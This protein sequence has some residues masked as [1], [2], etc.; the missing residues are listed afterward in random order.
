MQP[1]QLNLFFA[2]PPV[3]APPAPV[4]NIGNGVARRGD[5]GSPNGWR[6]VDTE[7]VQQRVK[8]RPVV[9][10]QAI[11][12]NMD[13]WVSVSSLIPDARHN[14]PVP[15]PKVTPQTAPKT[16]GPKEPWQM[17][18]EDWAAS[19]GAP[20][21]HLSLGLDMSAHQ[22]MSMSDAAKW[23]RTKAKAQASAKARELYNA[24][25]EDWQSKVRDA[26]E[27]GKF[28]ASD[29]LDEDAFYVINE[30][31][32]GLSPFRIR[33]MKGTE[34]SRYLGAMDSIATGKPVPAN[35]LADYP[36]LKPA[37]PAAPALPPAKLPPS[38][39]ATMQT[40]EVKSFTRRVRASTSLPYAPG[41]V[42][43]REAAFLGTGTAEAGR[44]RVLS[45]LR[46]QGP[47]TLQQ[48]EDALGLSGNTVRPRRCE[49]EAA[50]L[51][52][53]S[54]KT[55]KTKSGRDAVL[56]KAVD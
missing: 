45:L 46:R 8:V 11:A 47:M 51:V 28:R 37:A 16:V 14:G 10:G 50:G 52:V 41:S 39:H 27:Q 43:S 24:A 31:M 23:D 19:V 22:M 44:A 1:A 49:L 5:L 32:G 4:W 40:V 18:R 26:Y 55:A 36:N 12:D 20:K 30:K 29:I 3:A 15:P 54:G 56:W 6:V 13:E 42:T 33:Q 9:N 17:T 35:V 34:R 21:P 48:I 25:V 38:A 2:P 7:P 53:D